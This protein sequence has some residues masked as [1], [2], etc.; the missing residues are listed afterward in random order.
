MKSK[1]LF[2]K[3]FKKLDYL[4]NKNVNIVVI[5]YFSNFYLN[6]K[7]NF[8]LE[9]NF[10]LLLVGLFKVLNFKFF[11]KNNLKFKT[12]TL[13]IFTTNL[14]LSF[15]KNKFS[16]IFNLKQLKSLSTI[17]LFNS[18]LRVVLPT[19]HLFLRKLVKNNDLLVISL[20]AN[21]TLLFKH[22]NLG[23]KLN[24]LNKIICGQHWTNSFLVKKKKSAFF[25][26]FDNLNLRNLTKILNLKNLANNLNYSFFT[27]KH[28]IYFLSKIYIFPLSS[29][30]I[31]NYCDNID[32]LL[33]KNKSIYNTSLYNDNLLNSNIY[34]CNTI[35]NKNLNFYLNK[36]NFF[37]IK[38]NL[39]ILLESNIVKFN[40]KL[41]DFVFPISNITENFFLVKNYFKKTNK[42]LFLKLGPWL[43]R[44][45]F[46]YVIYFFNLS[47]FPLFFLKKNNI[48]QNINFF[49]LNF[50]FEGSII[51]LKINSQ[52]YLKFILQNYL[53][54]NFIKNNKYKLNININSKNHWYTEI[55]FIKSSKYRNI[56]YNLLKKEKTTF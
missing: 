44:S 5:S 35:L 43:S 28:K 30:N 53:N 45:F 2:L 48:F 31:V 40:S 23:N 26:N 37:E 33:F 39:F 11:K 15:F 32:F 3:K 16:K 24:V 19:F 13:N 1:N 20:S 56:G 8:F 25:F 10:N 34:I 51:F 7:I 42:S 4:S 9:P 50:W 27:I 12:F 36:K 47:I 41:W 14:S 22:L 55:S 46:N 29:Y 21:D 6:K 18:N 54:F 52:K 49:F 38:Y 17:I